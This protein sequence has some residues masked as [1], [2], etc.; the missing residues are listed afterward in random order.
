[1]SMKAKV[2]IRQLE[3]HAY[4][5]WH[6]HEGEFGQPYT[7]DLELLTDVSLAANSDHLS[8]AL[9]YGLI[10]ET[11]RRI[12]TERR[13]KLVESAGV[14][15]AKGLMAQFPE[16]DEVFVRV[17]KLKPPIPERIAAAGVELRMTREEAQRGA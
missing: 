16:V 9:D 13:H 1:M 15:L 10:V 11:T 2:V 6:P 5:G 3:L 4:H 14:E 17:L 7:I 12:F 8:D